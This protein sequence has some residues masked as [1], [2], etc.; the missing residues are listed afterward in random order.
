MGCDWYNPITYYGMMIRIPDK[1]NYRK[2]VNMVYM[3]RPFIDTPFE[4]VSLLSSFHSRME[5]GDNKDMDDLSTLVVGFKP[6]NN[7]EE[8]IR[9][10]ERLSMYVKET[11]VF[12]G[13][14][15]MNEGK[16]FTGIKWDD[17]EMYD[18]EEGEEE[19][20]EENEDEDDFSIESDD[21][22][23]KRD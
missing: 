17:W 15:I 23:Y 9:L 14:D 6:S 4:I 7:L 12:E 22:K 13:L 5:G 16:F 19:G 11:I 8:T 20:E 3:I 18:E 2:Y 1:E 10:A 21:E